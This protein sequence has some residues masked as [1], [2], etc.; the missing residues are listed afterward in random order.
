MVAVRFLLV[1]PNASLFH[2]AEQKKL[3]LQGKTP[4]I[5]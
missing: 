4:E 3:L 2:G 5:S 1:F